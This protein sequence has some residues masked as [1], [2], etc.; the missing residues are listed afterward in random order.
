[1]ILYET[2]KSQN[3]KAD[4]GCLDISPH[5][6]V[7]VQFTSGST[8][9]PKAAALSHYNIMNCGQYIGQQLTMTDSDR[10][11]LPASLFHSFGL[12]IGKLSFFFI[13][14]PLTPSLGICTSTFKGSCLVFPA[15]VF[16]AS[17]TVE[18]VEKYRCTGI[19]GVTTMFIE[20]MNS[21]N[22]RKTDRPSLK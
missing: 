3:Q 8:G 13:S 20:E 15:E 19:Y 16:N 17:A 6:I 4:L 7:N 1:M 12:I 2:L 5:D 22:F 11:C 18:C 14:L 10:V 21:T 9:T